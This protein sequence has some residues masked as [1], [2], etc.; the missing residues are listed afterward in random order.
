MSV[1]ADT[2]AAEAPAELSAA[3]LAR[4]S[5][6]LA[7]NAERYDRT[8]EFPWESIHAVHDAGL[9]TV[10]IGAAYGGRDVSVSEVAR[11]LQALGKGDP[12]VALLTAMT[13][14]EVLYGLAARV[15][16]GD[17]EALKRSLIAKLLITRSAITAVQTAIAAIGNPG[18][19]RSNPLERHFRDVQCSRIHP[20]QDDAALIAVGRRT[21]NAAAGATR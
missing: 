18:L 1:A 13:A 21:L 2:L 10:G 3:A 19:A 4:V 8:A 12:S 14:E 11:V 20:P 9:L 5:A 7:A 17:E 16:A 6:A 15:D